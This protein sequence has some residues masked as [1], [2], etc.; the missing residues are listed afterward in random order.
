MPPPAAEE[1][2]LPFRLRRS[3]RF[4]APGYIR[5]PSDVKGPGAWS[6][7]AKHN[8]GIDYEQNSDYGFRNGD[9]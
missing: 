6:Y 2:P 8:K 4:N 5:S 9:R 3:R 1:D 7:A